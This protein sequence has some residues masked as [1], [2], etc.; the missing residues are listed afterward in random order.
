[1]TGEKFNKSGEICKILVMEITRVSCDLW[2]DNMG[3]I[4][5][6]AAGDI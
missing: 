3:L 1:M 6:N 4:L 2:S 5:A